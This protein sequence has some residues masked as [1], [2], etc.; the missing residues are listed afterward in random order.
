M[1]RLID[2][3]ASQITIT[4]PQELYFVIDYKNSDPAIARN[5]AEAALNL[6]LTPALLWLTYFSGRA[7]DGEAADR[8]LTPQERHEQA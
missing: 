8:A 2:W 4:S 1:E 3:V 7:Q 6:A 5:V